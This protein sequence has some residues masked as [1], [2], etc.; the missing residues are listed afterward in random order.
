VHWAQ[1][2]GG[3]ESQNLVMLGLWRRYFEQEVDITTLDTLVE[4]GLEANLGTKEEI[5]EY[6]TSGRDGHLVD[7]VAEES[8][9]KGISGV[10]FYE[11]NEMWEVSGAQEPLAFERLFKR[12]KDL[13]KKGQVP[14]G[15]GEGDGK[16]GD[17]C[18]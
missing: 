6:L 9:M 15:G 13:E 4:I 16:K 14:V 1:S 10:P 5:T 7:K 17:A 12:W 18:L 2:H 3:E 8:M 11:V